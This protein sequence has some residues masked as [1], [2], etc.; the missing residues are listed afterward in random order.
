MPEIKLSFQHPLNTS[1]QV[2]DIAYFANAKADPVVNPIDPTSNL[3]HDHNQVISEP[4]HETA[5]QAD[6]IKIEV[7]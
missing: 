6:I 5:S 1:V 7:L 4:P 3:T 2:G